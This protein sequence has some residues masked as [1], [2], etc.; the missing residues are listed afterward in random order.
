MNRTLG[1]VTPVRAFLDGEKIYMQAASGRV[2]NALARNYE[3]VYLC[4]RIQHDPP[5]STGDLP[6]DALNIELVAQPFWRTTT[7]SLFHF[8]GIVRAYIQTCRRSDVLF[9]RGMCPY[10]AALY[11]CAF[12]Y[13]RPI[14]HWIIGDPVALLRTG[15]RKGRL[16]DA[17]SLLYALQDRM[18]SRLGRRLT[19][20][21][22]V[23]NGR[24][25]ARAYSSP[26]TIATVSSTVHENEFFYRAD[27][28]TR[29]IVRILFVGYIRPEK[30]LEYL[31][32]AVGRL[33]PDV[34]WEL[35]IIGPDAFPKYRR[36]LDQIVAAL[37]I[38]DRVRWTGYMPYGE[39]LSGRMRAADILV[40]PSLSEGTPHV[41]VEAKANS[42]P[43]I[44]TNVGGVPTVV[45][46]EFDA[47]LIPPK[48]AE[49]LTAAIER[50]I[51]DGDL[52]RS[53]IR[54]GFATAQNQTLECFIDTVRSQLNTDVEGATAPCYGINQV[55]REK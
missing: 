26:R 54:T 38:Q 18:F 15:T 17:I 5:P 55:K 19:D 27:T 7:G 22:F 23:C 40:L 52:R 39:P 45:T 21:A 6:L 49:T 53:L 13:R 48:D 47:L 2:A 3:K 30:G 35:E 4:A 1:Y 43:C 24:E 10:I 29:S 36:Q 8:F 14:C 46:H 12:L 50:I 9:V 44:S 20:G 37:G 25:L 28:C 42:L 34:P 31:L 41:L 51:D 16:L 33:E 11:L 32:N